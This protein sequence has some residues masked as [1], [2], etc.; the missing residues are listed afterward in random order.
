MLAP[1]MEA[2]S[3][4]EVFFVFETKQELPGLIWLFAANVLNVH[5]ETK[6]LR[7]SNSMHRGF[8]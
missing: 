2:L 3:E 7:F 8:T 1:S 5:L 4:V 6:L